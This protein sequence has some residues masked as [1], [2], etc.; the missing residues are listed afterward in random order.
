MVVEQE[1]LRE[2]IP[3]FSFNLGFSGN[4]F[5][6]GTEEENAGDDYILKVANKFWWFPHM[7]DHSQPHLYRNETK[8]KRIMLLNRNFAQVG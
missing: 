7:W 8:L 4:F 5:K 2:L 6:R 3:G 1:N